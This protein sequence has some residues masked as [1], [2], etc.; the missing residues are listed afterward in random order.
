MVSSDWIRTRNTKIPNRGLTLLDGTLVP[1]CWVLDGEILMRRADF[2]FFEVNG[3][4]TRNKLDSLVYVPFDVLLTDENDQISGYPTLQRL[5]ALS[6][7]F[8]SSALEIWTPPGE[9]PPTVP[10]EW[11]GVI[12]KPPGD[13]YLTGRRGWV[14]WK[15]EGFLI[16]R[17]LGFKPGQGSESHLVG[18]IRFGLIKEGGK[19]LEL[20]VC[21]GFDSKMQLEFTRQPEKYIG[22]R[23]KI[24]H[25]GV[26]HSKLRNPVFHSVLP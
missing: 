18:T 1:P 5:G 17:I 23:V 25:Y 10:P 11:E 20:G 6:D 8:G 14:K 2:K 9:S 15:Y 4:L 24:K 21:S 7:M 26:N 19:E 22:R 16:C 3:A 12:G 13:P